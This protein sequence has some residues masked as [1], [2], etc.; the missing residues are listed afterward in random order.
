MLLVLLPSS[1]EDA[2]QM[3]V[4]AQPYLNQ[5][6]VL[7]ARLITTSVWPMLLV[8]LPLSME[9]ALNRFFHL[10]LFTEIE[11]NNFTIFMSRRRPFFLQI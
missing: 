10:T 5:S 6:V 9:D 7:T 4:L 11:I 3:S 1:M 8:L 2:L